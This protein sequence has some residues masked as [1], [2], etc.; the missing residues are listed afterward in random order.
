MLVIVHQPR[1]I[2]P[3]DDVDIRRLGQ[4]PD[5]FLRAAQYRGDTQHLQV[6][7][8]AG[9]LLPGGFRHLLRRN[10]KHLAYLQQV[11][12]QP[13]DGRKGYNAF[14]QSHIQPKGQCRLLNDLSDAI[15]LIRMRYKI[16]IG[17][18]SSTKAFTAFSPFKTHTSACRLRSAPIWYS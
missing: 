4:R 6:G 3:V 5:A 2:I 1:H 17:S 13:C 8:L 11:I 16:H 15:G 10:D 9:L 18:T 12:P 14:A 7:P